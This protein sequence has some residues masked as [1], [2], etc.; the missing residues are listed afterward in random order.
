MPYRAHLRNGRTQPLVPGFFEVEPC[1]SVFY[2][3][4][5]PPNPSLFILPLLLTPSFLRVPLMT[6][7]RYVLPPLVATPPDFTN[8]AKDVV[9]FFRTYFHLQV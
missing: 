5:L 3:K 1:Y 4:E 7:A 8:V 2:L 9:P 6:S